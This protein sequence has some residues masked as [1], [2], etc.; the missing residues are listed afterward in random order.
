MWFWDHHDLYYSIESHK[1]IYGDRGEH[2]FLRERGFFSVEE[3][4]G[5][6]NRFTRDDSHTSGP[7]LLSFY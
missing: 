7:G 3:N 5:E 6:V 1:L 4:R 2:S